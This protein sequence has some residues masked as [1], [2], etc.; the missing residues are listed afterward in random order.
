[1]I[2]DFKDPAPSKFFYKLD[3]LAY[4]LWFKLL[5]S[6]LALS[7][8]ILLAKIFIFE[9]LDLNESFLSIKNNTFS[10]FEDI[11]EY[12]LGKVE[13]FGASEQLALEIEDLVENTLSGKISAL[14]VSNIREKV[15]KI[16]RVKNAF[17]KLTA[18]GSINV[19]VIERKGLA[20]FS[21]GKSYV[22][23]DI[24]GV[25]ITDFVDWSVVPNV[26]LIVGKGADRQLKG[27]LSLY[28]ERLDSLISELEFCEWVGER[29]WNLH[30][31][32]RLVVKLPEKNLGKGL[33]L[34][35]VFREKGF[36]DNDKISVI[37]LR[38]VNRPIIRFKNSSTART[39]SHIL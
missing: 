39:Y 17:V 3:R 26:P 34:L 20:V 15:I 1:M 38:H 37:D 9:K 25:R 18:N 27:F 12:K 22:L 33:E 5:L 23:L 28:Y 24:E 32:S 11:S 13:V 19:K 8:L 30:F 4:K 16:P 36:L 7:A 21:E 35:S 31:K 29:R 6:S 10:Y 14:S 2:T